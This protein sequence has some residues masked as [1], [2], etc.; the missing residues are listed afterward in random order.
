MRW[1]LIL[2]TFLC[3]PAYAEPGIDPGDIRLEVVLEERD[4]TTQQGEMIL[5]SIRGTYKIPVIREKMRQPVLDGFDWMQL[6][7]DR[8]YKEREDGFEVLK[9]ERRMALFPQRA[10]ELVVPAFTHGLEML[11]RN[12]QTVPI[13]HVS[14]T[15]SLQVA[16]RP[17]GEDWWFPV[18]AIQIE[19]NWS[20][21]P[22]ALELGAAALR[23]VSLTVDG[24]APQRIPPMPELTGAGAFIFPHPEHRI[25]ALGP[26][27]PRTRVFWRWTV[28]PQEGSAGYTN[29]IRLSWFNTET[30]E[31]QEILLSA[32]RVAY[33]GGPQE[34]L[35]PRSSQTGP[36]AADT[37]P[38][39]WTLPALPGWILPL[40]SLLGLM[41]GLAGLIW[42]G[43]MY[44]WTVPGWLRP[45]P[46][47]RVLRQA[48]E[49]GD[50]MAVRNAGHAILARDDRAVPD[51]L[52]RL[53][54]RL[55]GATGAD[56]DLRAVARAV[57]SAAPGDQ[58][59]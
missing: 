12:G 52:A 10:G 31:T 54:Q 9:L 56:P 26:E 17:D 37:E 55:F 4:H 57:I 51:A 36:L 35:Q 8:W 47:R 48:A 2:L 15:L 27:G 7:E 22:E 41:A 14:N 40:A 53:D 25:V 59:A 46:L 49:Q 43:R 20:N 13:D 50:A 30:Q 16:P 24:T 39:Y 34:V 32:Q 6:G 33:A 44:G 19:D 38:S 1:L 45:D 28:R 21:Q 5:L 23:V 3:V 58:S 42:Q 29:P 18:R 11:G